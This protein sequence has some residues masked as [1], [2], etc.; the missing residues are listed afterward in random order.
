MKQYCQPKINYYVDQQR[1]V[2][3]LMCKYKKKMWT[4]GSTD[5]SGRENKCPK[6]AYS[7]LSI[8]LNV[9]SVGLD[10]ATLTKVYTIF[11]DFFFFYNEM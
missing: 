10:A 2:Y 7:Q 5:I 8:G 4:F 9:N 3:F 6:G 11:F 1:K